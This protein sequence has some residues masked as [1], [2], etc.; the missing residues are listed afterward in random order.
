VILRFEQPVLRILIVIVFISRSIASSGE[1]TIWEPLFQS[2]G[3]GNA[4]ERLASHQGESWPK[5][6]SSRNLQSVQ[7]SARAL[8]ESHQQLAKSVLIELGAYDRSHPNSTISEATESYRLLV[9]AGNRLMDRGGYDNVVLADSCHRIALARLSNFVLNHPE[10]SALFWDLISAVKRSSL[11]PSFLNTLLTEEGDQPVVIDNL[12]KGAA[13][14]AIRDHKTT[15]DGSIDALV[16]LYQRYPSDL[17]LE[18]PFAGASIARIVET[19]RVSEKLLPAL[20]LYLKKGGRVEDI[21]HLDMKSLKTVM[22]AE[23][24]ESFKFEPLSEDILYSGDLR[25]LYNEFL[26]DWRTSSFYIFAVGGP[27]PQPKI[28]PDSRSQP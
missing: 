2:P 3:S 27:V 28:P 24:M 12:T 9:Q 6:C 7:A 17:L 18:N 22:G 10:E 1:D 15:E 19:Q 25:T 23:S 21:T 20:V 5:I 26:S 4:L 14:K 13:L 8:E 16:R 11:E